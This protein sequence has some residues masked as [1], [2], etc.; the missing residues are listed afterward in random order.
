MPKAK[1][2]I[3]VDIDEVLVPHFQDLID[4]YNRKYGTKLTLTDNH[5]TDPEGWGTDDISEAIR[6]VHGFF[7]TPEFLGLK[8]FKEP[9]AVLKE[10]SDRYNLVVVTARDTVLEK[11]TRDWLDEH[12]VDLFKEAHFTARFSLEGKSQTKTSVCLSIG[13]EY[14]V[15]DALDHCIDAAE[16]GI[17]ALLFGDYPWNQASYLPP[18]VTR[19]KNWQEVLDYF[20]GR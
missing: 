9:F 8:P 2:K 14:L 1:P 16:H 13:A 17:K 5:P 7:E 12:F 19:V 18:D 15:D 10:L 11:I 3:A 4:W 6:R 20:E